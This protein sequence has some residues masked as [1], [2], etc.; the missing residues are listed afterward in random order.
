MKLLYDSS[1]D[2][3]IKKC[4]SNS[5]IIDFLPDTQHKKT[6]TPPI[7]ANKSFKKLQRPKRRLNFLKVV[8]TSKSLRKKCHKAFSWSFFIAQQLTT[9]RLVV[10]LRF[11]FC[12]T[13]QIDIFSIENHNCAAASTGTVEK[14]T[15]FT[16]LCW[17]AFFKESFQPNPINNEEFM[18]F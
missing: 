12:C 3:R 5:P 18:V 6:T 1:H 2:F 11:I 8:S 15:I 16:R 7:E 14:K 9:A 4:F 10:P 13:P 17:C